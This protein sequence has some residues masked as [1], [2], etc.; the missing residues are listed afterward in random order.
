MPP[1]SSGC[2]G[3]HSIWPWMAPGMGDPQLS[4]QP[5]PLPHHPLIWTFN[6]NLPSFSLKPFPLVLSLLEQKVNSL[7]AYKLPPRIGRPQWCPEKAQ[8]LLFSKLNKPS[9]LNLSSKERCSSSLIIHSPPLYPLQQLH[10]P[11]VLGDLRPGYSTPHGISHLSLCL[12]CCLSLAV[13]AGGHHVSFNRVPHLHMNE[14]GEMM[15]AKAE[16]AACK[17]WL[18]RHLLMK[19]AVSMQVQ[20][21]Q[22]VL[23]MCPWENP[24]RKWHL[25]FND[26][27]KATRINSKMRFKIL[28]CMSIINTITGTS[29]WVILEVTILNVP[30]VHHFKD[31]EHYFPQ[32]LWFPRSCQAWLSQVK[33]TN[34]WFGH[35]LL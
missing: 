9:S 18:H 17:Q 13:G 26:T 24:C 10:I 6:L 31:T 33:V 12:S 2:P 11:P 35:P 15:I 19:H 14:V 16:H 1:I 32:E 29:S 7:L 3:P 27:R 28:Q 22:L 34:G 5:V 4:G 8:S 21:L 20:S 23:R 30:T 25:F